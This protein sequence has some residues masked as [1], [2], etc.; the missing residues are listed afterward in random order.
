MAASRS[1]GPPGGSKPT[2]AT[3]RLGGGNCQSAASDVV[4]DHIA[5]RQHQKVGVACIVV[6]I[7]ARHAVHARTTEGGETVG[8][9]SRRDELGSCRCSTE[10]IS[11]SCS[12]ANRE[13]LVNGVGENLLPTGQSCGLWWIGFSPGRVLRS[14]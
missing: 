1:G 11:N 10:M 13:V 8:G 4:H 12:D 6:G 9:S 2:L 7:G 14:P 3:S 5:L